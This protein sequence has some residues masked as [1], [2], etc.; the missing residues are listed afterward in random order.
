[1]LD[2]HVIRPSSSPWSS[3][4]VLIKK[5]DG[6]PR[7]CMNYR[8]LN[9]ITE[10]DVYPLPRIDDIIDKLAGSQYFTTLDLKAGYWQISIDEHDK[11]KT[12]FVT[13]DGLYEFNVLPFGLSNAHYQTLHALDKANVKLNASK[14]K[15]ARKQLD[16][17]G[18]RITQEGIKPTKTNMEKTMDFP[19][20]TPTKAAHSFLAHSCLELHMSPHN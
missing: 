1:M 4:V 16:Y 12:A 8:R 7:F 10:R 2:N 17:L 14:C 18:F 13:T 6:S 3:P 5:K 20:P 15:L 19:T 9:L 11:K